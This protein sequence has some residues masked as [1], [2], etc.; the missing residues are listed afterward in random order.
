MGIRNLSAAKVLP[1]ELLAQVSEA[2]GGGACNLW[3]PARRNLNRRKRDSYV[4]KLHGEGHSAG[5]IA[6]RLFISERTVWRV[7]ARARAVAA[8][9]DPAPGEA[10][11]YPD[12]Q[13]E[14]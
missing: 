14:A 13:K 9:S 5:D 6:E 1:P 12:Q 2:L 3:V 11:R 10:R 8:P 4:L 7:L